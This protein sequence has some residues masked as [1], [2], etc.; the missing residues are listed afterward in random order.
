MAPSS[1]DMFA[2]QGV[3]PSSNMGQDIDIIISLSNML[4][5]RSF[6]VREASLNGNC[7]WT[8]NNQYLSKPACRDSL[9]G[10]VVGVAMDPTPYSSTNIVLYV[11]GSETR[12]PHLKPQDATVQYDPMHPLL[13]HSV[14]LYKSTRSNRAI[15][16]LNR[17]RTT[18]FERG[19]QVL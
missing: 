5:I 2:F 12:A 4:N 18:K 1:Q 3:L 6:R 11:N 9:H 17:C 10:I 19:Y 16:R 15:D 7:S 8:I 14:S 13:Q